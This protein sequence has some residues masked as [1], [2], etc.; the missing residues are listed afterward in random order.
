MPAV[1]A[2]RGASGYA[3]ENTLPAFEKAVQMKSDAIECDI[4][5]TSDGYL[6]VHHDFEIGRIFA[7]KGLI[8]DMTLRELKKLDSGVRFGAEFKNTSIPTLDEMLDI[9]KVLSFINIEIKSNPVFYPNIVKKTAAVLK[10]YKMIEKTI[11]SSFD[12]ELLRSVK[13]ECPA[14][15]TGI[16]YG[17]PIEAPHIYAKKLKASALHPHFNLVNPEMMAECRKNGIAVNAW[18]PN[19]PEEIKKVI[20]LGC[21]GIITNYPDTALKLLGR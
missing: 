4:H 15:R 21:D 10:A 2:H 8:R 7:G 12:H 3:P 11:I 20:G 18:T 5:E 17:E 9:V 13:E 14:L 1:I 6:V 16:L 19:T